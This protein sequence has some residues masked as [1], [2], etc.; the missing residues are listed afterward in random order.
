MLAKALSIAIEIALVGPLISCLEESS[1]APT[2]V[3]TIA[4]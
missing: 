3:I 1:I 2:L 4:V